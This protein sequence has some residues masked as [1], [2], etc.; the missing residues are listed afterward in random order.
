MERKT[1]TERRRGEQ[2][3]T[4]GTR[5]SLHPLVERLRSLAGCT[6]PQTW[7]ITPNDVGP[8]GR[9]TKAK[10]ETKRSKNAQPTL[11]EGKFAIWY[12]DAAIDAVKP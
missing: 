8:T 12:P 7:S 10:V 9:G 3:P 2:G 5:H 4:G 6:T 1:E 11:C